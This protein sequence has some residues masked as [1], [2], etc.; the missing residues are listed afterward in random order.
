MY[1]YAVHIHLV[2]VKTTAS[3]IVL[4][5]QFIVLIHARKGDEQALDAAACGVGHD[6][7]CGGFDVVHGVGLP[8]DAAHFHFLYPLLI[9]GQHHIQIH[10]FLRCH[11]A[12]LGGGV[13]YHREHHIDGVLLVE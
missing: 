7:G 2:F 1:F 10:H 9:G 11:N 8:F 3:H 6:A 13:A 5:A 12:L 4:A